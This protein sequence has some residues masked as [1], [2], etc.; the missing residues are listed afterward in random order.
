MRK[1]V[2]QMCVTADGFADGESRIVP[3]FDSPYW[4]ELDEELAQTGAASVDTILL[5]RGTYEEFARYWPTAE[6]DGPELAHVRQGAKFLNNTPK[7]VFSHTLEK[8]SWG[9]ARVVS[10]SV[11]EEVARLK[12]MPGR[13]MIVPGGVRFPRALIEQHLVDEYLLTVVP[14]IMGQGED[15]L[16]GAH[17]NPR[18]LKLVRSRP[19][20][21]G[22]VFQ[23]Y[24]PVRS[25]GGG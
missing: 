24:E 15:R 11:A 1:L 3:E 8:A 10:G 18:Y 2:L 9:P 25:N 5:G 13:N 16:F 14:M 22:A 23:H 21:N 6:Q 4:E 19:F 20:S 12:A 7:V 17:A